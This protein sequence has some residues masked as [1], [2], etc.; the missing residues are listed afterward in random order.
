VSA[1]DV[2]GARRFTP[3]PADY[4][5]P[6]WEAARQGTLALQ[7]C[8][9][10]DRLV[11]PPGPECDRCLGTDLTYEPVSGEGTIYAAGIV[12]SPILPGLDD[13][14]PVV[15]ALVSLAEDDDVLVTTNIVGVPAEEA[16]AGTPVRVCFDEDQ[17]YALPLFTPR[18]AGHG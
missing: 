10:C 2:A 13:H 12:R 14:L 16:T 6:F 15:C 7:R 5:L 1:V 3:V 9:D 4:E 11:Y 18:A 8:R 17:P